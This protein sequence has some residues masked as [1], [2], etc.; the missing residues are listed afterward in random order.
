MNIDRQPNMHDLSWFVDMDNQKRL[1]LNPPYQRRSVWTSTDRFYFLDTIFNNYPCPAVYVQKEIG[2]EG[3]KYNVVDGKQRISTILNFYHNKFRLPQKFSIPRLSGKR[4][5]DL[6]KSDVI[7]FYN[8]VFLV[9]TL[10]ASGDA[11]WNEVFFRVNKNQKGLKEQELR[12]ARFDGWFITRA[13]SESEDPKV[14]PG[15]FWSNMK[16]STPAKSRRMK[17]IEFISILMLVIL[18]QDLVGFPQSNIDELYAKYDFDRDSLPAEDADDSEVIGNSIDDEAVNAGNRS[19]YLDETV[20][21]RE[22]I[23]AFEERF[24]KLKSFI[25]LMELHNNV[26]TK[27]SRRLTTDFYSIWSVLAL[28][29]IIDQ[30]PAGIVADSCSAFLS[31]VDELYDKAREDKGIDVANSV[32]DPAILRY[33]THSV[34]A[35]TTTE[36]RKIRYEALKGYIESHLP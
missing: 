11:D 32:I 2:N 30:L 23:A 4:F 20:I 13:E 10:K 8:Y 18:E 7:I 21:Y 24:L 29:D 14:E 31:G 16:I 34:G 36:Y 35:A 1:D 3:P 9:E 15:L 12:H 26:V 33:Y 25:A 27:H 28:S 22:D 6:D 19:A 17:D 5:K